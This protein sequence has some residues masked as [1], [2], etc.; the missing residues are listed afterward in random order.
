MSYL[1]LL[2]TRLVG[3]LVLAYLA[4][5]GIAHWVGD[6]AYSTPTAFV[7]VSVAFIILSFFLFKIRKP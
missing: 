4:C 3:P 5:Y 2:L 6:S 7:V 1:K